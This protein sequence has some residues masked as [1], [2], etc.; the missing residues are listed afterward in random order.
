MG[1]HKVKKNYQYIAE[2]NIPIVLCSIRL[3]FLTC[4]VVACAG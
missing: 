1:I 2:I 3:L 4:Y